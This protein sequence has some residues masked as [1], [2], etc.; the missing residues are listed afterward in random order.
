MTRSAKPS[1]HQH[2]AT[3]WRHDEL[4]SPRP[5]RFS[6]PSSASAWRGCGRRSAIRTRARPRWSWPLSPRSFSASR[7]RC[8]SSSRTS[9]PPRA[10]RSTAEE[11][12][13]PCRVRCRAARVL[14]SLRSDRGSNVV[15]LAVLAPGLMMICM[16]ILQFGLWFNA[17]QAAL[18]SAQAG[19]LVARE[20]A[21]TNSGWT[22]AAQDAA[23]Q[24]Y[25]NLHTQPAEQ[26][27]A[28]CLWRPGHQCVRHRERSAGLFGVS[29][30]RP[31]PHHIGH[32]W[33]PGGMLP[34]RGPESVR[35]MARWRRGM[36]MSRRLGT[37]GRAAR[38]RVHVGRARGHRPRPDRPAAAG[39]RGRPGRGGPG[40]PRRR[41]PGRRPGRVPGRLAGPGQPAGAAGGPGRPGRHELVRRGQRPGPG[42]RASRPPAS[43]SW[44][45]TT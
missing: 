12:L 23:A 31:Q 20:E 21:A 38:A 45:A 22:G 14:R 35:M 44:R 36:A 27:K 29:V 1:A 10:P 40:A 28:A 30:L 37:A 32:R 41:G 16:L 15:E 13:T 7:P 11:A 24:Y 9:S 34:A 2:V 3:R 43:W 5:S 18:A 25:G 6:G 42:R 19:A 26:D 17:R 4:I 33:R 39:R 8:F